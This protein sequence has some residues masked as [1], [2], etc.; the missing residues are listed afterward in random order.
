[1]NLI[2]IISILGNFLI[3][4]SLYHFIIR[5][6]MYGIILGE[7]NQYLLSPDRELTTDLIMYTTKV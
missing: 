6:V 4:L 5:Q 2:E 3:Y 1:M 7:T